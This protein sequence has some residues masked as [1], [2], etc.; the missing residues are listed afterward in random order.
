MDRM[1]E[2]F[3]G[4]SKK[5]LQEFHVKNKRL[6]HYTNA[7]SAKRILESHKLWMRNARVMNDCK[8]VRYGT[9]RM[10]ELFRSSKGVELI[11]AFSDSTVLSENEL[12]DIIKHFLCYECCSWGFNTYIACLAEHDCSD[13]VG[14]LSMWRSYGN[15]GVAFVFNLNNLNLNDDGIL[16][17]PVMYYDE[18]TFYKEVNNICSSLK[19]N[20]D[21]LSKISKEDVKNR[22]MWMLR[23]AIASIKHKG[24]SEEEEWR[25][26]GHGRDINL[27][28]EEIKGTVEQVHKID[29]KEI[30]KNNLEKIIIG[31]TSP[32][33]V[34]HNAFIKL[35]EDKVRISEE[36]ATNMVVD[37][38]IP[39]VYI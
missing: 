38:N 13:E 12:M 4:Y 20:K 37:S 14:K 35:L 29:I 28:V 10:T 27:E 2:I 19:E 8:E 11:R 34:L 7:V 31:P 5:R 9:E 15:N 16:L 24:F 30:L 1:D 21:V 32:N 23:Y 22:I 3:F 17:S 36:K 18:Q 26:V 39:L 25:L 33:G 6:I